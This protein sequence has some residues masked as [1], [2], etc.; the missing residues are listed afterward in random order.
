MIIGLVNNMPDGALRGTERQ[1]TELLDAASVH[2]AER[3]KIRWIAIPAVPRGTMA[4]AHMRQHYEDVSELW[5][6]RVDGLIVTGAEP[7]AASFEEEPYWPTLATLIEWAAE[8]TVSTIWSCLAAHAAAYRLDGI[9]RR[10]FSEK[11]SGIFQCHRSDAH[12]LVAGLPPQW[13]LPHSRFNDLPE[14][15]LKTSGY[16]I[17]SRLADGRV[18]MFAKPIKRVEREGTSLFVFM[19]GHPEYECGTL[20]REYH[21]DIGRYLNGERDTYPPMPSHYFD[22]PMVAKLEEFKRQVLMRRDARLLAELPVTAPRDEPPHSWH[23]PAVKLYENWLNY[24]RSRRLEA[25]AERNRERV[26]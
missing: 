8:N 9:V 10:R 26:S 16:Q 24:I 17:V 12:P 14:E 21:R 23:E 13:S 2:Y 20:L 4:L 5:N 7:K 19:Q 3:I 6:G 25:V 1:F 18:D 11:L 22:E 15:A